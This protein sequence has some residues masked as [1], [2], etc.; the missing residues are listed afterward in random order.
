M[1]GLQSG[2]RALRRNQLEGKRARPWLPR[3]QFLQ[4]VNQIGIHRPHLHAHAHE[5]RRTRPDIFQAA[6]LH[7]SEPRSSLL[8]IDA[9]LQHEGRIALENSFMPGE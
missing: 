7:H 5:I 8:D 2:H 6:R 4:F 1:V 9:P 3:E